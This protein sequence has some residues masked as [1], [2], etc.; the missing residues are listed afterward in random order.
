MGGTRAY[1]GTGVVVLLLHFDPA[2]AHASEGM[3]YALSIGGLVLGVALGAC[4]AYAVAQRARTRG[5]AARESQR[6]WRALAQLREGM[7]FTDRTG[8][9][10]FMNGAAEELT[11]WTLADAATAPLHQVYRVIGEQSRTPLDYLAARG[12]T[13]GPGDADREAV[14]L[15]RRDGKETP[16]HDSFTIVA[17]AEDQPG[18]YAVVFHD[19]S[20]MRMVAQQ[21]AWQGSHDALTGLL[22]KH[23][24]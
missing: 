15:I 14:R 17:A 19:V 6:A 18:G 8:E 12:A 1:V 24:V 9:I 22:N 13:G 11:G 20:R 2:V 5:R 21:L 16:V 7:I 3:G 23:A 10:V 4:A